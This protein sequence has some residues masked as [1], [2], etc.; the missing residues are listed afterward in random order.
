M[1]IQE[2][3]IIRNRWGYSQTNIDFYQVIKRTPKMVVIKEMEQRKEYRDDF[4]GES[5]PVEGK[6]VGEPE[7][8]KVKEIDGEEIVSLE[9][10]IGRKWDGKLLSFSEHA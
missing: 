4:E 6:L 7:R 10:G 2:G 5:K 1:K 8:K 9:H 3:D